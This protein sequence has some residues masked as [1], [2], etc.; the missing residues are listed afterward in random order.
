M[1]PVGRTRLE[2]VKQAVDESRIDNEAMEL[3][4]RTSLTSLIL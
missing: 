3:G 2:K 1:R 4:H